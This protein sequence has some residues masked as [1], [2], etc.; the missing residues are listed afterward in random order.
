MIAWAMTTLV[1]GAWERVPTPHSPTARTSGALC[2]L[3]DGGLLLFGGSDGESGAH[4][5]GDT[6]L[7]KHGD[8]TELAI[9]GAKPAG[10]SNAGL[11]PYDDGAV[12]FG[13]FVYNE[14]AT[15]SLSVVAD[16]W[17]FTP[18]GGGSGSWRLLSPD[19]H[20]S[21]RA[22][23]TFT[24]YMGG[25]LLFGGRDDLWTNPATVLG[26]TWLFEGGTWRMLTSTA[27][28]THRLQVCASL[29]SPV[30]CER[31][32]R[33]LTRA[34][35]SARCC[36]CVYTPVVG[37]IAGADGAFWPR[38]HM[39]PQRHRATRACTKPFQG[40][41]DHRD[42]C[43]ASRLHALRR[44][45]HRGRRL[46]CRR[47]RR[48]WACA[49]ARANRWTRHSHHDCSPP[50]RHMAARATAALPMVKRLMRR[51]QC[52]HHTCA[53]GAW[54]WQTWLLYRNGGQPVWKQQ[55][56]WPKPRGR[57]CHAAARCARSS[58]VAWP[59]LT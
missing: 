47:A 53:G 43:R 34:N 45:P 58:E 20:P 8:W 54:R 30:Q 33:A 55:N 31:S 50:E 40:P 12:L 56:E 1:L 37:H 59:Q 29:S 21:A 6:W 10:R 49:S 28:S 41:R 7:L 51:L 48:G 46:L 25:G 16:T 4:F 19:V 38:G 2:A 17:I 26:D 9:S 5:K 22:Y 32:S 18:T 42:L 39:R 35:T 44:V 14:T 11:V 52:H 27:R 3:R 57:W 23:F 24:P 36:P 13:G 15:A